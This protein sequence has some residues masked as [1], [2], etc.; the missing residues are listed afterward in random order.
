MEKNFLTTIQIGPVQDFIAASKITR[1]LWSGSFLLSYIM[2]GII[3]KAKESDKNTIIFPNADG[4]CAPKILKLFDSPFD[5]LLSE[6]FNGSFAKKQ[7]EKECFIP[8]LPNKLLLRIESE[9]GEGAKKILEGLSAAAKRVLAR[10]G[11]KFI[12]EDSPCGKYLDRNKFMAQTENFLE[13][14]WGAVELKDDFGADYGRLNEYIAGV[15]NTRIFR[16]YLE[17]GR[18]LSWSAKT[19]E[20]KRGL[21]KKDGL[22]GKDENVIEDPVSLSR[23]DEFKNLL[24][25]NENMSA[26]S[27]IKRLWHILYLSEIYGASEAFKMPSTYS[28]ANTNPDNDDTFLDVSDDFG[29]VA[30]KSRGYYAVIKFDGDHIGEWVSGAKNAGGDIKDYLGNFSKALS[31]FAGGGAKSAQEIIKN[32]KGKLIYA[33]GDDVLALAPAIYKDNGVKTVLDCAKSLHAAFAGI[34]LSNISRDKFEASC[35]VAIGHCKMPLQDVI[36]EAGLAEADAKNLYGRNSVAIHILKRNGE[37]VNCGVKFA[38]ETGGEEKTFEFFGK[39]LSEDVPSKL[40]YDFIKVLKLYASLGSESEKDAAP[41]P[42]ELIQQEFE[43]CL[44]SKPIKNRQSLARSFNAIFDG[45]TYKFAKENISE[46]N[47]GERLDFSLEWLAG[48]FQIIAWFKTKA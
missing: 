26:I 31:S 41:C 6:S 35:G 33:G 2:A 20:A 14:Y 13:I 12:R 39:M 23:V 43:S 22:S 9:S 27:L 3:H 28:I 1:D 37:S 30:D 8:S 42:K 36:K 19:S 11:E 47:R 18:G 40:P 48:L 38:G 32:F 29:R 7:I 15:K 21:N 5:A 46:K 16:N 34:D 4:V 44:N 10:V 25:G 45:D 17:N 24:R